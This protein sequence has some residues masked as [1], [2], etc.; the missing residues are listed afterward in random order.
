MRK[1]GQ[2]LIIIFLTGVLASCYHPSPQEAFNDLKAIKGKWESTGQTLFNE[3]WREVSD[4]LMTGSGFSLNG[5]DT[6]FREQMKIFRTGDS[7]WYAAQPGPEKE[8]VFFRLTDA[9]YGH[10]TFK[11]PENDYPGIISYKL[12][13]DTILETR[14][15]NIRGNKEVVFTFKKSSP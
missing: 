12:K 10:W 1:A 6:V 8:Y 15:T 7:I 3:Q 2:F 13:K 14:T 9:G 4:T 11:N 5:N